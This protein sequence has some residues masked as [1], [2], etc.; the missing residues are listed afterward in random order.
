[1][2][3][4]MFLFVFV[5]ALTANALVLRTGSGNLFDNSGTIRSD[6]YDNVYTTV[7]NVTGATLVKG[8]VVSWDLTADD[9]ASVTTTTTAYAKQRYCFAVR[10]CSSRGDKQVERSLQRSPSQDGRWFAWAA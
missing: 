7:K 9:G 1:M 8:K 4:L 2:K 5:I 6:G 10:W 3:K